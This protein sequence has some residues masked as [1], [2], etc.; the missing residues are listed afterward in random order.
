[1]FICGMS[2]FA[3]EDNSDKR[4]LSF[5][6][7]LGGGIGLSVPSKEYKEAF[8]NDDTVLWILDDDGNYIGEMTAREYGII[9]RWNY[10][11]ESFNFA[12]FVSLQLT[13]FFAVQTEM[14]F[15]KYGYISFDNFGILHVFGDFLNSDDEYIEPDTCRNELKQSRHALIFPILAK[16]TFRPGNLSIQAFAGPH[17]TINIG[18]FSEKIDGR[19]KKYNDDKDYYQ[20]KPWYPP[21]GLTTGANF[22]VKTKMGILFLDARYF[23][24]LGYFRHVD[25]SFKW[26]RRAGLSL[27]AGYEFALNSKN[28]SEH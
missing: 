5:G 9:L 3:Q 7:R 19:I 13:N 23:T 14:L 25:D 12:P 16:L 28:S 21:I 10:G 15:T 20:E 2:L 1:M 11:D 22:G 24:D 17:F 8:L 26:V 18:K 6:F 27:T 4:R